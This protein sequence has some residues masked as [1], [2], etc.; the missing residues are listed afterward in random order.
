MH[1]VSNAHTNVTFSAASQVKVTLPSKTGILLVLSVLFGVLVS[2]KHHSGR[3]TNAI[4]MSIV[5]CQKWGP[6][7][8]YSALHQLQFGLQESSLAV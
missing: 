2:S 6:F 8:L 1:T 4:V 3:M 7:A 5:N